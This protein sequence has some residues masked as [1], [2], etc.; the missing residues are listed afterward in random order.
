R[1]FLADVD[2]IFRDFVPIFRYL[3]NTEADL[4]RVN[5]AQEA[6]REQIAQIQEACDRLG[7]E[8]VARDAHILALDD[9][10]EAQQSE[11]DRLGTELVARDAHILA[12]DDALEAQRSEVDRLGTELAA[13]DAHILALDDALGA[14]QAQAEHVSRRVAEL[15]GTLHAL[16][17]ST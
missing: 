3:N 11:S 7:T 10:L 16:Q 12:L 5:T 15:A 4:H 6:Q 14:Q 8:L 1:Q 13:R 2:S 9:A 17:T